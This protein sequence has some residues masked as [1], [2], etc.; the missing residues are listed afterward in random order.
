M[1]C[2]VPA[3][4][5]PPPIF[6]APPIPRPPFATI[7]PVVGLVD[8]LPSATNS[9]V[10]PVVVSPT[11]NLKHCIS[12]VVILSTISSDSVYPLRYSYNII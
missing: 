9:L 12:L 1:S 2:D 10:L 5:R 8:I 11:T 4:D 7:D 6:A 3:I